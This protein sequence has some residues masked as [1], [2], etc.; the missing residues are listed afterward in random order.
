MPIEIKAEDQ[1]N[2]PDQTAIP[3]KPGKASSGDPAECSTWGDTSPTTGSQGV[4]GT[5][6]FTGTNG[7]D[8]I[9]MLTLPNIIIGQVTGNIQVQV[10]SANGGGGGR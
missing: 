4:T 6:G 7:A 2:Q 1:P 9:D 5:Q 3:A 8:G 10:H